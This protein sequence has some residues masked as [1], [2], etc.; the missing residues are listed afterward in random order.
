MNTYPNGGLRL[1]TG[2]L[3]VTAL[4]SGVVHTVP[5][6][7]YPTIQSAIDA[8][9]TGD[10]V[11][12]LAGTF[13]EQISVKDGVI[14]VSDDSGVGDNKVDNPLDDAM[15]MPNGDINVGRRQVMERALRTVIDGTG[16]PGGN[17]S[18]PLV[19]FAEGAGEATILDGFTITN[20]PQ[21]N[22]MLPDHA[23]TV[24]CR[25]ASPTILN[26]IIYNNGSSGIGSHATFND[27]HLPPPQ[28]DYSF[29]NIAHLAH[30]IISHNVCFKNSGSG[31]GNNYYS[32]ASI[33]DNESF[34]NYSVSFHSAPGIGIQHGAHPIVEYNL[35]H[36]NDWTGIASKSGDPQGQV[37]CDQPTHPTIRHNECYL[38]GLANDGVHGPGIGGH[39]VGSPDYHVV[40][41]HNTCYQNAMAGIGVRDNPFVSI[42]H[43][44][45]HHNQLAGI[46]LADC[47]SGYALVKQN[48]CY[49]N[50]KAGIGSK[51]SQDVIILHNTSYR[52]SK[53][54][55]G[56]N[57]DQDMLVKCNDL[58]ENTKAGLGVVSTTVSEIIGNGIHHNLTVGIG[59]KA[60][61]RA[62]LIE[63]NHV[64]HNQKPGLALLPGTRCQEVINNIFDVNGIGNAP[65]I[66]IRNT[67]DTV[68]FKNNTIINSVRP[69]VAIFG[70]HAKITLQW[71]TIASCST[72]SVNVEQNAEA[73]LI[74]NIIF[75]NLGTGV[76]GKHSRLWLYHN[77]LVNN[78]YQYGCALV[79]DNARADV[80]NNIFYKNRISIGGMPQQID[81]DNNCHYES[82]C[83]PPY[84]SGSDNID[85]DPDF[86]DAAN[87]NYQLQPSSPCI[88]AGVHIPGINDGYSGS[89]PDIGAFEQ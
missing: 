81:E 24:E 18:L 15:P 28:R 64:H 10:K 11:L 61:S 41:E 57:N 5:S 83:P 73:T 26:N 2:R 62:Q 17:Q 33:R 88:D 60:H 43:N 79:L 80:F 23:H 21:V 20:M 58:Y 38:N 13:N 19:K 8:S 67:H 45:C 65:N 9:A 35:T 59:L 39:N 78:G 63:A 37:P 70:P 68:L 53:V 52:N 44:V 40:I 42:R 7:Q 66:L 46:G 30:P 1:H 85:N 84:C 74:N 71:N 51:N 69:N 86:V 32:Y 49:N 14:I 82:F 55:I 6:P 27:G 4:E 25:G 76:R 3:V 50:N 22:H 56:L 34:G 89:A 31:I 75:D 29:S 54:G 87:H 36:H 47:V 72:A 12:V 48:T 16:F 77:V